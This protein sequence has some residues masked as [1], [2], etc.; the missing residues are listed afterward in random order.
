M[1]TKNFIKMCEQGK[2]I[3]KGWKPKIGDYI[4]LKK[5]GDTSIRENQI[6]LITDI[7]GVKISYINTF[8]GID[9]WCYE[10]RLK[11]YFIYLPT[12]EQLQEMVNWKNIIKKSS[13]NQTWKKDFQVGVILIE[14]T[15]FYKF[16]IN[17]QDN[18]NEL[19]LAFVMHEKYDKTWTG[20]KWVKTE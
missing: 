6:Y 13:C 4:Y 9:S 20:E 2:E 3:Q 5:N 12:Q 11:Y 14:L 19:W 10:N 15:D 8:T 7:V 16:A 18:L 17:R 1:I